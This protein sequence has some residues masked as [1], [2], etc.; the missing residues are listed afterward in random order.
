MD[1]AAV[2]HDAASSGLEFR[3]AADR[4]LILYPVMDCEDEEAREWERY[5][6]FPLD[7]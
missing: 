4:I 6:L 5:Y 2:V 1:A 7:L 3:L